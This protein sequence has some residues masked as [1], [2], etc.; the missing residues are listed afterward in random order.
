M[1]RMYLN[2]ACVAFKHGELNLWQIT[3]THG[4]SDQMPLTRRY[5][6]EETPQ[7]PSARRVA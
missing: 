7:A 1:W 2:S 4:F 6:Y 5:L 3:F